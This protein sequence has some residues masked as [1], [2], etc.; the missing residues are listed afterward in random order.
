MNESLI[1]LFVDAARRYETEQFIESDPIQLPHGY[2]GREDVEVSAFVSAWMAYGSRRVFIP[3]LRR[4]HQSMDEC[5][6]PFKFVMNGA[7]LDRHKPEETLYRF[8]KWTDY[9]ALMERLRT[10]YEKRGTLEAPQ[11]ELLQLFS[12]LVGI[13]KPD[14]TSASKRMNMFMRWM[15]R[16]ES[17]VDFGLWRSIDPAELLIPLDTHVFQTAKHY[18]LTKRNAPDLKTAQE[19]T[20]AMRTIWPLDPARGDFALYGLG[21]EGVFYNQ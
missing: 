1:E 6:G 13:P 7:Y 9:A 3:L 4:L 20:A 19:I 10:V 5:G 14:G 17:P 8:F 15:V 18:N 11:S 16:R 12:G 21:L 2:K